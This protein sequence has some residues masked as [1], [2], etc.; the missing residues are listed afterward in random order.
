VSK[1]FTL[2]AAKATDHGFLYELHRMTM[3]A[4][5]AETWGWDESWQRADFERRLLAQEV[6]IVRRDSNEIGSLW[7]E[8]LQDSLYIHQ[9]AIL[10]EHHGLGTAILLDTLDRGARRGKKVSLS[11]VPANSG[12]RRLYERLGFLVTAVEPPFIRMTHPGLECGTA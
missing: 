2:R 8:W 10:P 7:L 9:V 4:V 3:Q 12:A 5:I 1:A 11:V 6:E